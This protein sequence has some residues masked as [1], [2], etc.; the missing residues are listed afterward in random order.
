MTDRTSDDGWY[1]DP[2]GRHAERLYL[3]GTWTRR[4]R[5]AD[6]SEATEGEDHT[7]AIGTVV[8]PRPA[9][10]GTGWSAERP[11]YG[12]AV[13]IVGAVLAL[14]GFTVF[15]WAPDYSFAS[16]RSAVHRDAVDASVV[17]QGYLRAIAVPLLLDV[18]VTGLLVSVGRRVARVTVALAGVLGGV[19]LVAAVVWIESGAI[20]S[21]HTRGDAV[22]VLAVMVAVG[23]V[24]AALGAGAYFDE[25]ATFSRWLAAVLAGLAVVLHAYV[26][27]DVL[28][29]DAAAGA[30]L[31]AAGY[32][33]LA[34]APA[35]PYRRIVHG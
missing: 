18:V 3:S 22:P 33:A 20:G 26:V 16:L 5:E 12:L 8:R 2:T 9:R 23:I 31:P 10:Q 28:S 21:A 15:D 6:G 34:V 4:V 7:G 1:A 29:G 17:S 13:A 24:V 25:S 30:W 14:L 27:S 19:G 32:A 11:S 35:L